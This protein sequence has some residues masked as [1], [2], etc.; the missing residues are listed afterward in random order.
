[1]PKDRH[2]RG[3]VGRIGSADQAPSLEHMNDETYELTVEVVTSDD[4]EDFAKRTGDAVGKLTNLAGTPTIAFSHAATA[5]GFNYAAIIIP[6][7][8]QRVG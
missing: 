8:P 6:R 5:G 1:M 4:L 2:L 7:Q 3:T